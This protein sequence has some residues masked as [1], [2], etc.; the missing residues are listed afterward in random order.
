MDSGLVSPTSEC[1]QSKAEETLK[2]G[3][4]RGIREREDLE[5]SL[6]ARKERI[7]T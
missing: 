3:L 4:K 1:E 5:S 6:Y 2:L 7:R